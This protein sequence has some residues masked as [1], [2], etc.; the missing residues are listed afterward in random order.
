MARTRQSVRDP[1]DACSCGEAAVESTKRPK[2]EEAVSTDY[3]PK[4]FVQ[5][6]VVHRLNRGDAQGPQL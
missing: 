5:Y 6:E 4:R 2:A 1:N 3:R